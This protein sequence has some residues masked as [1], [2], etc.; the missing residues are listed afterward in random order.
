MAHKY[1]TLL[2]VAITTLFGWVVLAAPIVLAAEEL[3][4]SLARGGKLYDRWYAVIGERAPGTKHSLYPAEGKYAGK[5]GTTWRCKECHGWDY[6]GKDGAYGKGK[7]FTGIK[8][9]NGMAGAD[10]GKI[11]ALLKDEKHGYAGKLEDPDLRAVALFVSKGQVNMDKHIDRGNKMPKGDK[12]KGA[13]YYNTLCAQCHG[14]DGM[15]I[16][17]AKPLGQE[18]SNPWEVMHKIL[19]GQPDEEMVALRALDK[20]VIVDILAHLTTLPKKR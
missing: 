15:E 10:P 5:P 8:G 9:I 2:F 18:M 3:Q 17:D 1:N 11:V 12:K 19:N 14:L 6:M 20:Q 13:A 4:Y 7:H 16:Q